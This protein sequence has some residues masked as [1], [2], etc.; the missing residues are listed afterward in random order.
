MSTKV[1]RKE[2]NRAEMDSHA[3]PDEKATSNWIVMMRI[4]PTSSL[5]SNAKLMIS[6][7]AVSVSFSSAFKHSENGST[8][9]FQSSASDRATYDASYITSKGFQSQLRE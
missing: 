6:G 8:E 2:W 3:G 7:T 1:S 4:P 9:V 5:S